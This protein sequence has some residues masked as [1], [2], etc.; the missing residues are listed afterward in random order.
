M[1]VS[2]LFAML[3]TVQPYKYIQN[4]YAL[5]CC[6][7]LAVLSFALLTIQSFPYTLVQASLGP[8]CKTPRE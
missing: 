3:S 1:C 8:V 5:S 7:N 6:C 2:Y 4:I